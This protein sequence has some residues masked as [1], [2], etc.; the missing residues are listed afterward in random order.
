LENLLLQYDAVLPQPRKMKYTVENQ[1]RRYHDI[2]DL[3]M[4]EAVLTDLYPD[5]LDAYHRVMNRKRLYANNMF[6][7]RNKDYQ[8]FMNWWF[9]V[10][11]EFENRINLS[12]YT[13]YQK[14]IIGF[15]AERLLNVW[16]EKKQLK[17]IELPVIY[18]KKFK[19]N[20]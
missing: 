16:F 1:Y 2:G 12:S 9:D 15:I 10:I 13:G 7:L 4:I 8:E 18:F 11:F 5:Y 19:Y 6:I 17:C 20:H 3:K 14:R